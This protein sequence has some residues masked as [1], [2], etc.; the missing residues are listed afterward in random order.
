M[1]GSTRDAQL[2][3]RLNVALGFTTQKGADTVQVCP[4]RLNHR[5]P[6]TFAVLI[7]KTTLQSHKLLR[8]SLAVN[9]IREVSAEK[10][11]SSYRI[12]MKRQ[13]LVGKKSVC[14]FQTHVLF[15]TYPCQ[16]HPNVFQGPW[17]CHSVL[18]FFP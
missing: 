17:A 12:F 9:F 6:L 7:L 3:H 2:G 18:H 5:L 1:S 4:P 8:C 11:S 14:S 10:A 13:L 16:V 15:K